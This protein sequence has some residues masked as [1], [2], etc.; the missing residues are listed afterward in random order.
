MPSPVAQ[1]V[2]PAT[3]SAGQ[4]VTVTGV[5]FGATQ[6]SGSVEFADDGNSPPVQVDFWSDTAITFTVPAAYPG[7]PTPARLPR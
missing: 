4:Q 3:A 5:G 1:S 2:S 6:G 7:T